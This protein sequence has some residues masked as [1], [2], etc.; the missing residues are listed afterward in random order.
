MS[1][2]EAAV[3]LLYL[4]TIPSSAPRPALR[5]LQAD[6]RDL[7]LPINLGAVAPG[8]LGRPSAPRTALWACPGFVDG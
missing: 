5:T 4:R 8:A 2:T 6:G 7:K 3:L 1:D